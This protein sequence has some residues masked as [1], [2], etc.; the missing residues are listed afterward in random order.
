MID[1]P[2]LPTASLPI[3]GVMGSGTEPHAER[4]EPLGRWLAKLAVHLLTGGGGGVMEA[5]S[6]A[7]YQDPYRRGVII[8]ILPGSGEDDPHEGRETYP[9]PWVEVPIRTHLPLVGLEGTDPRSRN[10][11][12]ILSSD[13]IVALPGSSGTATEVALALRYEKPIVAFLGSREDIPHL[14][15]AVPV[16]SRLPAVQA[17]VCDVLGIP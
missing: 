8:G 7:F 13:V 2:R 5:V 17:F 15:E 16:V 4:S 12:N 1:D 6:A 3:V 14:P 11:I 10:H 9:N